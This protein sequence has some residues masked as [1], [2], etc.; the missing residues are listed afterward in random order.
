MQVKI[1]ASRNPDTLTSQINTY[2]RDNQSSRDRATITITSATG[3]RDSSPTVYA[4][5]VSE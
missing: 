2:L 3:N 4:L 5:I 1:L